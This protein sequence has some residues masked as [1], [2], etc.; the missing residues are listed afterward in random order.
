MR[1]DRSRRRVYAALRSIN[2]SLCVY[3]SVACAYQHGL[4]ILINRK[5]IS[6]GNDVSSSGSSGRVG[7]GQRSELLYYI[8]TDSDLNDAAVLYTSTS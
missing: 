2:N 4:C 5:F 8:L 3:V 6:V 7:L 1:R